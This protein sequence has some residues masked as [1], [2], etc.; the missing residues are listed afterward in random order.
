MDTSASVVAMEKPLERQVNDVMNTQGV[1]GALCTD[2]RGLCLSARG[3]AEQGQAGLV[4]S[5][6]RY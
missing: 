6:V 2:S 3:V 4:C 5:L 1:V